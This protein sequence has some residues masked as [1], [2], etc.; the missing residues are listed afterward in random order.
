MSVP[1][2]GTC[3]F[4]DAPLDK[5]DELEEG[6]CHRRAPQSRSHHLFELLGRMVWAMETL[7]HIDHTGFDYLDD[8]N[9]IVDV[10][11][12]Q[13]MADDSCGEHEPITRN[14]IDL[15]KDQERY[16]W[17]EKLDKEFPNPEAT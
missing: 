14:H 16:D 2:C 17:L 7:A 6:S 5:D 13:T 4:W 12:P 15:K 9:H 3:R 8:M 1:T 11:W 10:S